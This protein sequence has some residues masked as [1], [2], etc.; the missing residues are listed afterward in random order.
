MLSLGWQ[1][2]DVQ[3]QLDKLEPVIAMI[4]ISYKD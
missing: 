1:A 3:L 2:I 4:L